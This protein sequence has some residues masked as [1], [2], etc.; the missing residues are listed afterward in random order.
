MLIRMH[1]EPLAEGVLPDGLHDVPVLDQTLVVEGTG[2]LH[3][4]SAEAGVA[5]EVLL[6]LGFLVILVLLLVRTFFLDLLSSFAS[7]ISTSPP[8]FSSHPTVLGKTALGV[9]SPA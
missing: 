1:D 4:V 3:V 6:G 7:F 2:H 9:S 5:D 8:S